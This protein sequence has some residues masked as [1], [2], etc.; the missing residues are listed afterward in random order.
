MKIK[1]QI[2]WEGKETDPQD[3]NLS[4]RRY[5]GTRP[6]PVG[7]ARRSPCR[8]GNSIGRGGGASA[9]SLKTEAFQSLSSLYMASI[10][11]AKFALTTFLFILSVGVSSPV[12]M[13]NSLGSRVNLLICSTL[14]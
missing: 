10:A 14:A 7:K 11:S 4:A 3:V 5:G 1:G 13:L 12:S 6:L 2:Y 9:P 8:P